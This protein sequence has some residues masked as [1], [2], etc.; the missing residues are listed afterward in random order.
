MVPWLD[1]GRGALA[2]RP[3]QSME[4][5]AWE[6][7]GRKQ[8]KGKSQLTWADQGHRDGTGEWRVRRGLTGHEG[9]GCLEAGMA[10]R[11][12]LSPTKTR[13]MVGLEG[14]GGWMKVEN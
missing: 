1:A 14:F 10:G 6:E 4:P 8:R 12:V 3:V 11:Q 13:E 2:G 9:G 5:G 7:V